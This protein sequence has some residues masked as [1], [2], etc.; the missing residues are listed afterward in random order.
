MNVYNSFIYRSHESQQNPMT[1]LGTK[2]FSC[3]L[4][5]GQVQTAVIQGMEGMWRQGRSSQETTVQPLEQGPGPLQGIYITFSLSF[6]RTKTSTKWRCQLLD[7]VLFQ[8]RS[9]LTII[10]WYQMISR[11]K[12]C[13]PCRHP[14]PCPH[15]HSPPSTGRFLT[16]FF[17]IPPG[18][19]TWF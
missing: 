17:L 3:P 11:L 13:E 4:P 15:Q 8:R 10:T 5:W 16:S 1:L 2:A 18:R 19:N 9:Q 7:E 12:E 14:D 6:C